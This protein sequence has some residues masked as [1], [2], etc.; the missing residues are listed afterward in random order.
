M[1][2]LPLLRGERPANWRRSFYYRYYHDPGHHNTRAHYAVRTET[3]KLIYYFKK[4]QWECFDL[5]ND[6]RELRNI[7]N[8]AAAQPVVAELKQELARLRQQLQDNDE[9][10]NELP[11][12]GVDG[13]PKKWKPGYG[14]Q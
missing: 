3:H 1:S 4:D 12:D 13:P 6:P 10:A 9:F 8:E 11:K 7:Y 5:V 14:P 2:L